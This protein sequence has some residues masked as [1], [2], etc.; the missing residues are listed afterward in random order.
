[1]SESLRGVIHNFHEDSTTLVESMD[2]MHAS[3]HAECSDALRAAKKKQMKEL[4]R[5]SDSVEEWKAALQKGNWQ[6]MLGNEQVHSLQKLIA[7][8]KNGESM[9]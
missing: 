1:M 8:M 4:Q 5:A 6:R 2:A 3:E 7:E 9:I